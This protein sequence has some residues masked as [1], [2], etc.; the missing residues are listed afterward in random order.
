M[1]KLFIFAL[2]SL[3]MA[4]CAEDS[5]FGN[6]SGRYIVFNVTDNNVLSEPEV[7]TRS[8]STS[9]FDGAD[10]FVPQNSLFNSAAIEGINL[11][12]T[13]T[14]IES[15][16][17]ED[18]VM[19]T[20]IE[21]GIHRPEQTA[22]RG[23]QVGT[24]DTFGFGVSEYQS[25][26]TTAV[27]GFQNVQLTGVSA[28]PSS[29]QTVHSGKTWESNA[30]SNAYKFYAYSP[31]LTTGTP[32]NG[33]TLQTGNKTITYDCTSV[34]VAN[35]Q[36]LMTAYASS[37]YNKD[38]VALAFG[39]RLCA[40][41]IQL[42]ASWNTNYT[43]QSVSFSSVVKSGTL[44]LADGS[45]GS[46]GAAGAYTPSGITN[47]S[48]ANGT[49]AVYLMMV[50]QT[51]SSCVLTVSIRKSGDSFDTVLKTTLSTVWNA[52]ETVT[53]TISPST[54]STV[55]VNYPLGTNGWSDG[56]SGHIDGPVTAYTASDHFGLF[57]VD[58][59]G[60]IVISN[61]DL[62]STASATPSITLPS[63]YIYSSQY[64]Y[65][66]YYPYQS[67]LITNTTKYNAGG[68]AQGQTYSGAS[69]ADT[70][71]ANVITNWTVQSDQS[72]ATNYKASDLQV[73]KASGTAFTM[74]HK[75]GLAIITMSTQT[76]APRYYLQNNSSFNWIETSETINVSSSSTYESTAKPYII[77]TTH[78]YISKNDELTSFSTSY[79][80]TGLNSTMENVD[81]SWNESVSIAS[82]NT[83]SLI[84]SFSQF[85]YINQQWVLEV[86]DIIFS[87]RSITK[88][89]NKNTTAQ[90]IFDTKTASGLIPVGIV[91]ATASTVSMPDYDK[92]SNQNSLGNFT[93]GYAM[94]LKRSVN[95]EDAGGVTWS[96][97]DNTLTNP[98]S[99]LTMTSSN[100]GTIISD[101]NGLKYSH[102]IRNKY[103]SISAC[104]TGHPAVGRALS[105]TFSGQT[106]SF[107]EQTSG[108]YLPSVGQMYQYI[109]VF[110]NTNILNN[111]PTIGSEYYCYWQD[112]TTIAS[113][114]NSY[115]TGA[116]G[117]SSYF[118][119]FANK[120]WIWSVS[121][122]SASYAWEVAFDGVLYLY[123]YQK[124]Q[125]RRVR[126]VIAF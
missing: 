116:L 54:I 47:A 5:E 73:A 62:T 107:P 24:G 109:K 21:K 20:T 65:Y 12:V 85:S 64:T 93:H 106:S 97:S 67:D 48:A 68:L 69:N 39:H 123:G 15:D 23:A 49:V 83:L 52:G 40:V 10:A 119:A 96:A 70:F 95:A 99:S 3:L 114:I 124:Q 18:L 41:K 4:A 91:F 117:S 108:W 45:W 94:A 66:L 98:G 71:F 11:A 63:G 8:A 105:Y 79:S 72:T 44:S 57:A 84:P 60:K 13:Q 25:D 31:T 42:G 30:T 126:A 104:I 125:K 22:T 33:L 9:A 75:M 111:T 88:R 100:L 58:K 55:T 103:A 81:N 59:D 78:Y 38:G 74:A 34:A 115:L 36:D 118:H 112:C 86:G 43:I 35:Q 122:H 2:T 101:M 16:L 6:N 1:K 87:D 51:L 61:L 89:R 102:R 110:G 29:A 26:G 92:E 7:T 32:S 113:N 76:P 77:G 14:P 17:D 90:T 27:A 56:S 28:Q 19:T 50:P 37:N 120:Q 82:G 46:K 80:E 121:E 53:Y